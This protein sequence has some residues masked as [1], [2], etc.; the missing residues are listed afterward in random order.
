[1][2]VVR[3]GAITYEVGI[4]ELTN[5]TFRDGRALGGTE[6]SNS[7]RLDGPAAPTGIPMPLCQQYADGLQAVELGAGR[8][9]AQQFASFRR[10]WLWP[11]GAL[12]GLPVAAFLCLSVENG[13]FWLPAIDGGHE[14]F[15]LPALRPSE[16]ANALEEM[17]R[18]LGTA[19][20]VNQTIPKAELACLRARR[21]PRAELR[22]LPMLQT[23]SGRAH[24]GHRECQRVSLDRFTRQDTDSIGDKK[25]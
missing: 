8:H 19:Q 10:N 25:G 23:L 12:A 2:T 13:W 14:C 9:A 5:D 21:G 16:F 24:M 18:S 11:A 20:R 22:T 15:G 4:R 7:P 17:A 1:M 6:F 3:I